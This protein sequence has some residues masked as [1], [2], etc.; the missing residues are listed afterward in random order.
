MTSDR[1]KRWRSPSTAEIASEPQDPEHQQCRRV[2]GM[3]TTTA[4]SAWRRR[5]VAHAWKLW[6]EVDSR[7]AM[8][9]Q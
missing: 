1:W 4:L 8:I 9:G 7:R 5:K 3:A 6:M 2:G